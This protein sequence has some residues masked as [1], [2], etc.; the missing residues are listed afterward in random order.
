MEQFIL[1][2]IKVTYRKS[3]REIKKITFLTVV[4]YMVMTSLVFF[5]ALPLIYMV[6]TAFKPI[7]ELFLYPPRFLVR[8]PTMENMRSLLTALSSVDVPFSR[9][10]LNS[11]IVSSFVVSITIILCG[12][13]AYGLAIHNPKGS[14]F[15]LSLIIAALMFSPHV[16]QIPTYLVVNGMNLI[17][18]YG[19]LI[20]PR[21][22]VAYNLFLM[23]RFTRQLPFSLIESARIEGAS[24]L[25][26]FWKIMMPNIKP[27]W[28]TLIALTFISTWNDYFTPL[29]FTTSQNMKTLPLALQLI[30]GGPA[31]ANIG[32]AGAV[33]AATLVMTTPVVIVF[34]LVQRKVI[35]TMTHSGIKA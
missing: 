33:A 11:I 4:K 31:V 29:V 1:S 21:I 22:A 28:A 25:R 12:M 20:L 23:E 3:T 18:T 2:K 15:I 30:A 10:V 24:E 5:F 34:I 14:G 9:Y 8:N 27:A 7:D 32:R 19:A 6:S 35:E 16:T 17:D 26:I 13:C